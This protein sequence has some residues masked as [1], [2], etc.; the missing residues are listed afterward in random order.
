MSIFSIYNFNIW[1][2]HFTFK[3]AYFKRNQ[4]TPFPYL[5]AQK[6]KT[7]DAVSSF[8]GFTTY[9]KEGTT[10]LFTEVQVTRECYF[11][12]SLQLFLK[13]H[14]AK[15]KIGTSTWNNRELW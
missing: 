9:K 10:G 2:Y 13:L 4:Y 1:I 7:T 11:I 3:E 5:A 8:G 14:G 6:R 12:F 15:Y